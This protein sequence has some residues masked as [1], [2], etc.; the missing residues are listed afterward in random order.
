MRTHR[1]ALLAAMACLPGAGLRGFD[2]TKPVKSEPPAKLGQELDDPEFQKLLEHFPFGAKANP[3]LLEFDKRIRKQLT[4]DAKEDDR[5]YQKMAKADPN[6]ALVWLLFGW[7]ASYNLSVESKDVNERYAYAKRGIERLL[8]G[9][10]H[11]PTNAD[12]FW[13]VGWF[14][15]DLMGRRPDRTKFRELFRKDKE[16]HKLLAK[17]VELKAVDGSDGLPDSFLVAQR[18][19]EKTITVIE[20]HGDKDTVTLPSPL[21]VHAYPAISQRE[22]AMAIE[23]EGRFDETAGNAWKRALKLWDELGE[24]EFV[25]QGAKVRL[26]DSEYGRAMAN[27]DYWKKRCQA[28]Q[29]G[30]VLAARQAS[31]RV[32]EHWPKE[33]FGSTDEERAR[34]KRLYDQA[35][36][37][38]AK[39]DKEHPDLVENDS[40][41]EH[42]I[43]RYRR[44]VL[45]GKPLPDDFPF[46]DVKKRWPQ[47]PW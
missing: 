33:R 4:G 11:N 17:H 9:L 32:D 24:R 40:G 27:Y 5:L 37:A 10:G 31:Y 1:L 15:Q 12:L 41:V 45:N 26:K 22:H 36:G 28:E 16:F 47:Q 3:R 34:T 35:I 18:W 13:H 44:E 7:N 43:S 20:K 21:L 8:E 19:F 30:P 29:T 2:D 38:W 25:F 42:L 39:V 23:D 14:L 46:R 6:D